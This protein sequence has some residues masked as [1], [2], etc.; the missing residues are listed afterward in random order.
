MN[1]D[2]SSRS[3]IFSDGIRPGDE[4]SHLDGS[5]V[6]PSSKVRRRAK[7]ESFCC[8]VM[9]D[10]LGSLLI[11]EPLIYCGTGFDS[12]GLM[13][14]KIATTIDRYRWNSL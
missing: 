2:S 1:R 13:A 6:T 3:V 14:T 11:F 10:S 4:N 5:D 9:T 12:A 7:R 8:S